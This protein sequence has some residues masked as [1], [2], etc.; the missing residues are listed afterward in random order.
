MS[1]SGFFG[2][3]G[4]GEGDRSSL[5]EDGLKD[6]TSEV[7]EFTKSREPGRR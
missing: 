1:V 6:F 5:L 7:V 2:G 3:E 4:G